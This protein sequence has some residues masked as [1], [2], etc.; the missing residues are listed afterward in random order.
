MGIRIFFSEDLYFP[1]CSRPEGS[2]DAQAKASRDAPAQTDSGFSRFA[3]LSGLPPS[4]RKGWN[5]QNVP[6][7]EEEREGWEE[8]GM[9]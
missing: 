1:P 4:S 7:F 5:T 2:R 8:A 3:F 6:D 9:C